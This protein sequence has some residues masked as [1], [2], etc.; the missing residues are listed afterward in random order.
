MRLTLCLL[1]TE[2]LSLDFGPSADDSGP[3]T[4]ILESG[5]GHSASLEV[6]PTFGFAPVGDEPWEYEE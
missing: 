6:A 5:S 2:M 1:G 3:G 4:G